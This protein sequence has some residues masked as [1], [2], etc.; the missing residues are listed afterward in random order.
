VGMVTIE[1]LVR[2]LWVMV[3]HG[4]VKATTVRMELIACSATLPAC[5]HHDSHTPRKLAT[6]TTPISRCAC[7]ACEG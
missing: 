7:L 1:A 5:A 6:R 2:R 4:P 3:R